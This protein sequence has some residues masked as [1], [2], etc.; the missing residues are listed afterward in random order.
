M[1][2]VKTM[3]NLWTVSGTPAG[4]FFIHSSTRAASKTAPSKTMHQR[5]DLAGHS[6]VIPLRG[7]SY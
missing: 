7:L 6:G 2:C 4:T 1:K 5:I 3:K